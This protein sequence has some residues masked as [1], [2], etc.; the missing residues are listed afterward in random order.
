M[1]SDY[2]L[3]LGEVVA[4]KDCLPD[5]AA[6]VVVDR[7]DRVVE[8]DQWALDALRLANQYF[9]VVGFVTTTFL[10]TRWLMLETGKFIRFCRRWK[11]KYL[12]DVDVDKAA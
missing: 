1:T 8:D 9:A 5:A 10:L 3:R 12:N 4:L 2:E 7:V 6:V 11:A